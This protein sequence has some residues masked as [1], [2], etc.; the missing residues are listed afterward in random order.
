MSKI[1]LL[2][3]L[4]AIS[5]SAFLASKSQAPEDRTVIITAFEGNKPKLPEVPYEYEFNLPRHLTNVQ[6]RATNGYYV[7][8][9]PDTSGIPLVTNDGSTLGRVLFYDKKISAL[10]NISCGSCHL[11]SHAFGDDRAVSQGTD[12]VTRRNSP[13]LANLA[14]TNHDF[15]FW[16]FRSSSL[17]DAIGLPLT[18]GNEIGANIDEVIFKLYDTDYYPEL[19]EKAYGSPEITEHRIKDALAQFILSITSFESRLD[20]GVKTDF[21]NFTESEN[22]GR[23]LFTSKCATCHFEGNS[24]RNRTNNFE[25]LSSFERRILN[26]GLEAEPL[27]K[28]AGEWL[29][30]EFDGLYK[31]TSLR[32]IELTAPYM[33]NGSIKTLKDVVDH[34]SDEVEVSGWN[35]PIPRG[36]FKFTSQEKVDL[37]NFMKTMTD[38]SL[39]TN[40]KWSDPFSPLSTEALDIDVYIYPNPSARDIIVSAPSNNQR[41]QLTLTTMDGQV[42]MQDFF[43]GG[44]YIIN[45]A[46]LLPGQYF[47]TLSKGVQLSTYKLISM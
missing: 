16:D 10:E 36:G 29:G 45:K 28:G 46:D 43:D 27:D 1:Y 7:Q 11:Q 12:V 42:V 35:I 13:T 25:A 5:I 23:N 33:H 2:F 24:F 17:H 47:L 15:M 38:H 18:D 22:R 37:V 19:F 41:I 6:N 14:W 26:N 32:N 31:I 9:P 39:A 44:Q 40:P 8:N 4:A 34:Y 3:S 20:E 21:V 30:S